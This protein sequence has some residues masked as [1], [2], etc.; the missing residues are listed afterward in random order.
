M[1]TIPCVLHSASSLDFAMSIKLRILN[2]TVIRFSLL[3][4]SV[5]IRQRYD[6]SPF[7]HWVRSQNFNFSLLTA[8]KT[9]KLSWSVKL[10]KIPYTLLLPRD[11]SGTK[12]I[13]GIRSLPR[14]NWG[15][16]MTQSIGS[17]RQ[18]SCFSNFI[19]SEKYFI[20]QA[21]RNRKSSTATE[22]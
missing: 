22:A 12:L 13:E 17:N 15:K 10:R 9:L 21:F 20:T 8:I 11:R 16:L 3:L 7:I 2:F 5:I 14:I 4:H 1:L 6:K 19:F 18:W